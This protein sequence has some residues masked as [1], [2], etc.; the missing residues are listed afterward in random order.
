MKRRDI[1]K[2]GSGALAL[3]SLMAAPLQATAADGTAFAWNRAAAESLVG[4][5]FWLNHPELHAVALVLRMVRAM[6]AQPHVEQFSLYFDSTV[7]GIAAGTYEIENGAVGLF[8]LHVA[9]ATPAPRNK[10]YR[11]DFSLLA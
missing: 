10:R 9:P 3:S 2:A 1:L 7:S 8:A 6:P 11:A 4:Q 5:T